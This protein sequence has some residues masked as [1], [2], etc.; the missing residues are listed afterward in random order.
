MNHLQCVDSEGVTL[1]AD[2][3]RDTQSCVEQNY[4]LINARTNFDNLPNALFS[5]LEVATFK[6]WIA[7]IQNAVDSRV[8]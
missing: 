2:K 7:L 1:S 6:G 8:S 3:V 4:T 5:L